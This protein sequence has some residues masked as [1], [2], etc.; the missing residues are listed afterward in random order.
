ML[1]SGARDRLWL[2]TQEYRSHGRPAL[3][4]RHNARRL[5]PATAVALCREREARVPP[6][7]AVLPIAVKTGP[8]K[9]EQK[10]ETGNQIPG[11][12]TATFTG[13]STAFEHL[14][15]MS[16]PPFLLTPEA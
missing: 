9:G 12:R 10:I 13:R 8:V 3:G 1:G 6:G 16:R 4:P 5:R 2:G 14:R 11:N 7:N 15:A